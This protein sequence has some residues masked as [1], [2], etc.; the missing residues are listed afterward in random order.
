M[1]KEKKINFLLNS[2]KK[3]RK[4]QN[5]NHKLTMHEFKVFQVIGKH[6]WNWDRH[7][8]TGMPLGQL[9]L[10]VLWPSR[11]IKWPEQKVNKKSHRISFQPRWTSSM[12]QFNL[13]PWNTKNQLNIWNNDFKILGNRQQRTV[14]SER[15]Q[16]S[17]SYD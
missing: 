1:W 13:L 15:R 12:N 9:Q 6:F 10:H 3:G 16:K 14:L 4:V 17:E 5:K 8:S 7:H 2:W 11:G